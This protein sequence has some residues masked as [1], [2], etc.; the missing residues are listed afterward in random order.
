MTPLF[1][2]AER[3]HRG[4]VSLLLARAATPH[5]R[6]WNG[7]TPLGVAALAGRLGVVQELLQAG[8]EIQTRD[9]S[10][11]TIIMNVISE[12]EAGPG[13]VA[14]LLRAGADPDRPNTAGMFPLLAAAE[15]PGERGEQ[16]ARTLLQHGARPDIRALAAAAKTGNTGVAAALLQAGVEAKADTTG[17]GEDSLFPLG[18]ATAGGHTGVARLLLEAGHTRC[19]PGRPAPLHGCIELAVASRQSQLI[20]LIGSYS[21]KLALKDEL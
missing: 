7:L 4:L 3:G 14:A 2:A 1:V 8:A 15:L 21:E 6:N 12:S 19:G 5:S 18:L 11:N 13:V 16:L 10:G 9:N 17:Q 20:A